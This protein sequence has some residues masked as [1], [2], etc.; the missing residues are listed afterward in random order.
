MRPRKD[1]YELQTMLATLSET[2]K[3]IPLVI[4]DGIYD[5]NTE[6]AVIA[7]QKEYGLVPTGKVDYKTWNKIVDEYQ[8]ATS[9]EPL[10][11]VLTPPGENYVSYT[12][13]K[14]DTVMFAKLMLSALTV[15][16]D[17]FEDMPLDGC[18]DESTENCIKKFQRINRI[19]P[20]GH[21]DCKTWNCLCKNYNTFANHGG[22]IG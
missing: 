7:F 3:N 8:K 16:Y 22:Y 4:H 12:G 5:E 11:P 19:E 17:D 1:V 10:P 13:E 15:A 21:I 20:T 6:S 2:N 9:K 14:S 18:C